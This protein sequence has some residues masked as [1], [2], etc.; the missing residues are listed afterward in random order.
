MRR[1]GWGMLIVGCILLA[2]VFN[3]DTSVSVGEH[4]RVNNLGLM[5][6]KQNYLILSI[7]I[8]FVGIGLLVAG[9]KDSKKLSSQ[10]P[11]RTRNCPFCAEEILAQAVVCKYCNRDVPELD[12]LDNVWIREEDKGAR[13]DAGS[14]RS[15]GE[16]ITI[17]IFVLMTIGALGGGEWLMAFICSVLA[18]V[19]IFRL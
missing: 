17:G 7:A 12:R 14:S 3:L 4:G 10:A 8:I 11:G 15:K 6:E 2:I 19:V 5:N 13:V 1:L 16:I 18:A 9:M